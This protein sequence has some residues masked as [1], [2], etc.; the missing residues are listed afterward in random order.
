MLYRWLHS[1]PLA[2]GGLILLL[3][4]LFGFGVYWILLKIINVHSPPSSH[5]DNHPLL[6]RFLLPLILTT[7]AIFTDDAIHRAGFKDHFWA[8]ELLALTQSL[9][10]IAWSWQFIS[11]SR[12]YF[13]RQIKQHSQHS[14]INHSLSLSSNLIIILIIIGGSFVILK[15][16]TIDLSPLL[17]S[18]GLLTAVGAIAARDALSDFL[19]GITIFLDKSYHI[20]DYI[21]LS[22]GERGEVVNIGIRSTRIR[23]RDDVHIAVPNSMMIGAKLINETSHLPQYRVRCPVGIS[24]ICDLQEVENALLDSLKDNPFVLDEP[25]PRVRCRNFGEYAVELELLVW[26]KDPRNRGVT[27]DMIIREIHK[28]FREGKIDIPYPQNEITIKNK[29][30]LSDNVG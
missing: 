5:I 4:A 17:T 12:S 23:T 3:G 15:I 14:S 13:S 11:I 28:A 7:V 29:E 18:A 20:G 19:G 21:V 16:W 2:H 24:Y 10:V 30:L 26:I 22:T 27:K 9:P 1:N 8:D 25:K 6:K